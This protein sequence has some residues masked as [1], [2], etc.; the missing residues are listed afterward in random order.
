M[1]WAI[2]SLM[3]ILSRSVATAKSNLRLRGVRKAQEN[4][5]EQWG[6]PVRG[7]STLPAS[8]QQEP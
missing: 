2:Y 5:V 8:P 6:D 7:G 1:G 4:L 3:P